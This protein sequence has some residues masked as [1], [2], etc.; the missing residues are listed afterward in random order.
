MN[1]CVCCKQLLGRDNF[2]KSQL[3]KKRAGERRCMTCVHRD[4]EASMTDESDDASEEPSPAS[5]A[6][7]DAP[8]APESSEG[9]S[10]SEIDVPAETEAEKVC[11]M[12]F[13]WV[14][15]NCTSSSP[16]TPPTPDML[17]F[18]VACLDRLR[19]QRA[20]NAATQ[21]WL[22]SLGSA[23]GAVPP[24]PPAEIAA[25]RVALP[26]VP[27][28]PPV[29]ARLLA[30]QICA[31]CGTHFLQASASA[32]A[33]MAGGAAPPSDEALFAPNLDLLVATLDDEHSVFDEGDGGAVGGGADGD[34]LFGGVDL[35]AALGGVRARRAVG[36]RLAAA[37][38][39][40]DMIAA[41]LGGAE[42]GVGGG[43]GAG[44]GA[45]G[46]RGAA[47]AGLSPPFFQTGGDAPVVGFCY[48]ER[49]LRHEE[50]TRPA[51]RGPVS[52]LAAELPGVALPRAPHTP[53][54]ERPDRLRAIATH[55][56]AVGL[57]SRC[58]RVRAR[59]ARREELETVHGRPF[60][61]AVDQLSERVRAAGGKFVFDGGDTFANAHTLDA[62]RLAAG[63]VCA[64]T[65]AV[66]LAR[67]ADRGLAIVRPPGHHAEPDV[68]MG[69]CVYNNVAV[70][71]AT[72]IQ[73]WGAQRVLIL[74]W[75]VHHGNGTEKMFYDDP[76]VLYVSIHRFDNG[77]FFPGTGAPSNIGAGA[78]KGYNINVGWHGGGAGDSECVP[79]RKRER[80]LARRSRHTT[81][82]HRFPAR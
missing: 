15:V 35:E 33:A 79:L 22:Q 60:L 32:A 5:P 65:E 19:A 59:D 36:D 69:F 80:V 61:D 24:S 14:C 12:L 67:T 47:A 8:D 77:D 34:E 49:M 11:G 81:R 51:G 70:A 74:D 1:E 52:W 71:A 42:G 43:V 50:N 18:G 73:A 56:A 29:P 82:Q 76:R 46:P 72:A 58:V 75:D 78:G 68:A 31:D 16:V 20:L 64:V 57:L 13:L 38:V 66:V 45:G 6:S 62:A 30:R 55:L 40:A 37:R 54:P 26:F 53:H 25:L 63:A 17:A 21:A 10:E 4:S 23:V 7:P 48:D 9:G 28:I 2:S 3:K 44:A 41:L 27:P 39:T